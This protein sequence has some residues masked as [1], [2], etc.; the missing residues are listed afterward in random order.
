[1][2]RD[3]ALQKEEKGQTSEKK[4]EKDTAALADADDLFFVCD[5]TNFDVVFQ[6]CTWIIDSGASCHLTPHREFFSSYTSG[7]F[8]Y[9]KMG[10]GADKSSKIVGMGTV[11]LK[12]NTGCRLTLRDVRHVPEFRYNLISAG[13]L[14]E[15][16]Y[17]SRLGEGKWK[18]T[19]GS[20]IV[21][22]DYGGEDGEKCCGDDVAR[23]GDVLEPPHSEHGVPPQR[24]PQMGKF[25]RDCY[26]DEVKKVHQSEWF[27]AKRDGVI[28]LLEGR[29]HSLAGHEQ[30]NRAETE[31]RNRESREKEEE[32]KREVQPGFVLRSTT[33]RA[34]IGMKF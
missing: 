30:P 14:D 11:C 8:G 32:R 7:D 15:D 21:A 23:D 26:R 24:D 16:G 34:P 28:S 29:G 9:V 2:K 12:T 18:L 5:D 22:R 27:Q 13:G 25:E 10:K 17:V 3:K 20:L 1:M 4:E 6:D 31:R 33:K 19:K